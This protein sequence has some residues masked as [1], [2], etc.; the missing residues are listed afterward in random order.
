MVINVLDASKR[1]RLLFWLYMA[2]GAIGIALVIALLVSLGGYF[3]AGWQS[4]PVPVIAPWIVSVAVP[5]VVLR[6]VLAWSIR[7]DQRNRT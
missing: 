2:V 3:I 4:A 7:R 6:L 5:L 1:T